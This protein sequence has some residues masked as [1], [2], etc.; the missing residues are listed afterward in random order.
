[1]CFWQKFLDTRK[2]AFAAQNGVFVLSAATSGRAIKRERR[3]ERECGFR[4]ERESH[5]IMSLFFKAS[6]TLPEAKRGAEFA[7]HMVHGSAQPCVRNVEK[8]GS[9]QR[10][11][12]GQK[13][14]NLKHN[15]Y[16]KLWRLHNT[17]F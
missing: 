2:S 15:V 11:W 8:G 3:E 6:Q 7:C 1:M 16:E 17:V 4:R 13:K 12:G 14:I 9:F 10:Y 5:F